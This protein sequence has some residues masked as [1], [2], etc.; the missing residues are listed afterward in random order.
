[1]DAGFFLCLAGLLGQLSGN[2]G[3]RKN[4][5]TSQPMLLPHSGT[6]RL[7]ASGRN[8]AEYDSTNSEW[9]CAGPLLTQRLH[10][11]RSVAQQQIG[12]AWI[13]QQRAA[14]WL[15][16]SISPSLLERSEPKPPR[17]WP[18]GASLIGYVP[19]FRCMSRVETAKLYHFRRPVE[20]SG[21]FV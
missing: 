2:P 13:A 5:W 6:L 18:S 11:L 1:M 4:M 10:S 15:Y 7:V 20:A 21:L 9:H 17:Q 19:L 14:S 12:T 3:P 16:G 8:T